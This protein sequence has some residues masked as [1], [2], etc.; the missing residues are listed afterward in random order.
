MRKLKAGSLTIILAKI[1]SIF[2]GHK[3]DLSQRLIII[4]V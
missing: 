4:I 1:L 2:P 3:T